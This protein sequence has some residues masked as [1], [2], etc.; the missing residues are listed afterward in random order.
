VPTAPP[1]TPTRP[2]VAQPSTPP[3]VDLSADVSAGPGGLELGIG[4]DLIGIPVIP[5]TR[6]GVPLPQGG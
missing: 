4:L 6:L 2:P 1:T 5:D 3:L